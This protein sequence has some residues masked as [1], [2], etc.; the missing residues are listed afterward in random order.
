MNVCFY[1]AI[2]QLPLSTVGAIEFLGTV[3]LA[4][5]GIRT[6][7]NVAALA[8]TMLGVAF[9]TTLRF[10]AHLVAFICAFANCALFM[11]Y[12]IL[13]HRVANLNEVKT[14]NVV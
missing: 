13:G 12:L 3:T 2:A 7:R 1:V 4:A 14:K 11:L 9:I 8:L 6:L 10:E 5:V